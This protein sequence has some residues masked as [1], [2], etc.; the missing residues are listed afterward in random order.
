MTDYDPRI[1][2]L[3]D[4]DNPDGPDHDFYRALADQCGAQSILDLGC[5][6][7]MLTVT[8]ARAGRR[9]VGVDPSHAM[10]EVARRRDGGDEVEWVEGDSRV[11]PSGPFDLALMTGNAVQHIPDADWG[12][13]LRDLRARMRPGGTLSFE[14]RNPAFGEWESWSAAPT[15]RDTPHGILTEWM[16]VEVVDDRVVRFRAHNRFATGETV[17]EE[18]SLV[19]RDRGEITS[20]LTAAGFSVDRVA[21]EWDGTPFDGTSRVMI[22]VARAL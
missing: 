1:V 8:V 17:V 7:G 5:G 13:T 21:G 19:F 16:D 2:D 18:Q 3:Y 22:F 11:A 4:V 12:R 6:T 9:A 14:S 15:H 10:L 20:D